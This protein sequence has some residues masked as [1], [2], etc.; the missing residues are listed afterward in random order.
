MQTLF[1]RIN[2]PSPLEKDSRINDQWR[3][4]GVELSQYYFDFGTWGVERI[5][6]ECWLCSWARHDASVIGHVGP[7]CRERTTQRKI[8]PSIR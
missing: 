8:L 2:I 6:W 1:Q 7:K 4:Q 3:C 5:S